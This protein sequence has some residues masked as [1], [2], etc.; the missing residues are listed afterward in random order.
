MQDLAL[1][2][3]IKNCFLE[4]A[5]EVLLE[6]EQLILSL[7]Q[8]EDISSSID[9]LL[10]FAHNMKGSAKSVEFHQFA[11][12][13]HD[14][15]SLLTKIKSHHL[16]I[17]RSVV[18]LLFRSVDYMKDIIKALWQSY[19]AV[20]DGSDLRNEL[21]SHIAGEKTEPNSKALA[22]EHDSL[23]AQLIQ[24]P[25]LDTQ[26]GQ[27]NARPQS[28]GFGFFDEMPETARQAEK[29][30]V[31][32]LTKTAPAKVDEYLRVSLK[33]IDEIINDSGEL[34]VLQ[35][36]LM[37]NR[38][39]FASSPLLNETVMQLNKITKNIQ[40]RSM[41][42]RMVSL[43]QSFQKMQRMVRDLSIELKKEIAL[44]V[45][46]EDSEV[47][48]SVIDH[49][50]DPLLHL[51]RNACDHGLDDADERLQA[52][53]PAVGH[54]H[55]QA[56]HKGGSII[57]EVS[58]DGRGIDP[59]KV[60]EKARKKGLIAE[61][62]AIDYADAYQLLF[63]PGFSTRDQASDISGRGVG[64]D[65]VKTNIE[66][67]KGQVHV[68]S[69]VG[70]GT[71]FSLIL[72]LTLAIID[73]MIIEINGERYVLPSS[74]VIEVIEL[75]EADIHS[76][77]SKSRMLR[78]R[79]DAIPLYCLAKSLGLS[80]HQ[81]NPAKPPLAVI[82]QGNHGLFAVIADA[83]VGQQQ[84]VIKQLGKDLK[85]IHGISGSCILGDGRAALIID[86]PELIQTR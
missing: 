46:G 52:G 21:L 22:T 50:N 55:L 1:S 37:Q 64:L 47:D 18:N 76:M 79:E 29:A 53:K 43:K 67:L 15:E 74:Q 17:D 65:V 13:V 54:I 68:E 16:L 84:V 71:K 86:L 62:A 40:D 61:T 5:E 57:I 58:D 60:Y 20:I 2:E 4:E 14:F 48:K 80:Q 10:R 7:E 83:I 34:V 45:S 38:H 30:A 69:I 8:Q 49:I 44:S 59:Q 42:L 33:N 72:P 70:K 19:D 31:K 66:A 11:D 27:Q 75:Q 85:K 41:S 63:M 78:Y 82:S 51:I 26:A 23:N 77:D 73:A 35:A 25:I 36:V 6:T 24:H 3:E 39:L 9:A 81:K 12:F 28:P 56:Y 32:K